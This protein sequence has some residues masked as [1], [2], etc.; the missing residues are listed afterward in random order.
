MT[1]IVSAIWS[2]I[3]RSLFPCIEAALEEELSESFKRVIS[4]LE[5][6]RVEEHVRPAG[7][8]VRGRPRASRASIARAFVAKAVLGISLTKGLREVL[9]ADRALRRICGF[10]RQRDVPSE[11]T[12]SRVFAEFAD[13]ELGR[14]VHEAL[15]DL[16]VGDLVVMHVSRDSTAITAREKPVRKPKEPKTNRK[17]GRKGKDDPPRELKRLEKQRNQSPEEAFAE[18]SV[19]CDTGCKLD[20]HGNN[21]YWVGYKEHIDWT[22]NGFPIRRVS[23]LLPFTIAR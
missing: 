8:Q 21:H 2:G 19:V 14:R 13:T 4:T 18:L 3:E 5:I 20:T 17:R 7:W 22:D 1:H 15:T 10:A 23:R 12:L 6:V 16:H 9:L 11:S